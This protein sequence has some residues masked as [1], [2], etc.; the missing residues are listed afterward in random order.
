MEATLAQE[1]TRFGLLFARIGSCLVLL[2][3]IGETSVT[4]RAR[5]GLALFVTL[6]LYPVLARE[7]PLPANDATLVLALGGEIAIGLAYGLAARFAI[8][9][10][11][12]AGGMIA[13]QSGLA[14]A[15]LFDPS[16]GS[17][18]TL[19]GRFLSVAGLTLFLVLD[20]HHALLA[21]LADSYRS[22]PPAEPPPLS[23]LAELLSVVSG[24]LWSTAVRI[25]A[26]VFFVGAVTYTAFGL[27]SRLVPGIQ[28]FFVAMPLQIAL[29]VAALMVS[30]PAALAAFLTF[31]DRTV[32]SLGAG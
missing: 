21:A 15:A 28:I 24:G 18:T 14:A 6:L 5:L 17:Q 13:L 25:A 1:V 7:V 10:L 20:G 16:S 19:P 27:F 11:E 12:L 3:G 2:P 31:V 4:P 32:L 26:P 29:A 9:A 22:L 23:D 30:L 8:A